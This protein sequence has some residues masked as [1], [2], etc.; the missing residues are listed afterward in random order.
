[1][2]THLCLA[3]PAI[4][5]AS[6]GMHSAWGQGPKA[7]D[8]PQLSKIAAPAPEDTLD[9]KAK[10]IHDRAVESLK[11]LK[12]LELTS[13]LAVEG[14]DPSMIPPGLTDP[15]HVVI[16]FQSSKPA[17]PERGGP[18]P[19]P[20]GRLAMDSS[21]DG[22]PTMKF[23]FDGKSAIVVDEA[24]KSFMQ[25]GEMEW[26]M[27]LGQ[28][29]ANLPQWHF[30][31]RMDMSGVPADSMPKDVAFT[32]VG[33]ETLDGQPCDVVRRVRTMQLEGMQD[34]S[35]KAIAGPEL[36]ITEVVAFARQDGLAAVAQDPAPAAITASDRRDDAS[37]AAALRDLAA[38]HPSRVAVTAIGKTIGDRPIHLVTLAR[39]L[40]NADRRPGILVVAGMDGHRWSGTEAVLLALEQLAAGDAPW[41]AEVTVY[42]V[43]R[44][45]PDAS[46]AFV[47]G[48]RRAYGGDDLRHDNDRDGRDDEDPPI[49]LDGDGAITQLR[50]T[51]LSAPW[52]APTLAADPAEPRLLRAPD[53]ASGQMAAYTVW[54][55]GID[56]DGDGSLA[57]DW[58]GG[59]NPERNF[60]H[61]WPE[62]EDEAGNYP[63]LSNESKA[64][65]EFV[66]AHPNVFAALV[67]GRHDTVVNLPDPKART[68]GG[69]PAIY[70]PE[71]ERA[72]AEVAKA[73]REVVGQKRAEGR[74]TSGSFVAWMNAQ[75]GVPTFASTLWGRPDLP[76]PNDEEK[77]RRKDLPR[78]ADAEAA[79]W[80]EYSDRVRGGT[81][82]VPWT[83]VEHPQ[84][85]NMEVGGWVA[86]FRENPPIEEVL[87]LGERCAA[88]L[89]RLAAYRPAVRISVPRVTAMGPGIWR[90]EA[91][92]T[93]A[94]KLPTVMRGGRAEGVVPAH[95]VR[96][97]VPMDRVK[98]GRRIDVVRGLDPGEIRRLSWIVQAPPEEEVAVELLFGGHVV[99]RHAFTD[100]SPAAPAGGGAK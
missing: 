97:S 18:G 88:F 12:G 13:V 32:V 64:L 77:A 25:C 2:T 3:L 52:P 36:R 56:H 93:N 8:G 19:M 61:R 91:T 23:C 5:F 67:L 78:P 59:F 1:M 11:K 26:P 41:L 7:Q 15:V 55:E 57:E 70:A 85:Q 33:E 60:P 96:L 72:Y 42:A 16:D 65:A 76:E 63:L 21:K 86:G 48:P 83:R 47:R 35:G 94:G 29:T 54:T 68:P 90:I 50:V 58:P 40:A 39:D 92:L 82:F 6:V 62:F 14:I 79:A 37:L 66:A 43:P 28:R 51:G 71:D 80:L 17:T 46:A 89:D 27:L 49:D 99:E 45:N 84:V 31:N 38:R 81:G 87:P 95:V 4:L 98:S 44:G 10:A 53:A 24:A 34:D 22:K 9:P 74:D 20:F 69:M 100:G 75:R 73:W 30:E